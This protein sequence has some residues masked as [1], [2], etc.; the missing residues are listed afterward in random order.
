MISIR[1]SVAGLALALAL[2]G[3][4]SLGQLIQPLQFSVPGDPPAQLRLLGA[5]AGN[6]LGS[7]QLRLY[8]RVGNPNPVGVSLVNVVGGLLLEGTPAAE[9]DFPLGIPL[10]AGG[11]TVVPFDISVRL[12][13][14]PRLVP[15]LTRALTGTPI[16][17]RLDGRF[18]VDAGALGQPT[19]GPTTLLRGTVQPRR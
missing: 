17:Y 6:P 4:A 2:A 5:S 9:V 15:T 16:E 3:C 1:F 7:L 13:D 10:E 12:S 18:G 11:E 14:V 19:F 8:A